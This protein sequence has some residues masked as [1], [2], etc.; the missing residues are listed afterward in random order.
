MTAGLSPH[1]AL[2]RRVHSASAGA[3]QL[4]AIPGCGRATEAR[5]GNGLSP[6]LCRFHREY[7]SRHGSPLKRSYT[8]AE[9]RPHVR[10]AESFVKAHKNDQEIRWSLDRIAVDLANAGPVHRVND[11]PWMEPRAK[12]RAALAM[13]RE[14]KVP[15][16]RILAVTLGVLAAIEE[17]AYGPGSDRVLFRRVQ[18]AKALRRRASGSHVTYDS[19]WTFSRYPRSAGKVLE[20]L[21]AMVAEACQFAINRHL[22]N[23]LE[24]KIERYGAVPVPPKGTF[25]KSRY[26]NE[27]VPPPSVSPMA[28]A[29][30]VPPE[31]AAQE[32]L[33][34][35]R[36]AEE[37]R[38]AFLRD[39]YAAFRGRF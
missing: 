16:V 6:T 24:L 33:E 18:I 14:R 30:R 35:E 23:V 13:L 3:F 21:G 36:I 15:P 32:E 28:D 34:A 25:A 31:A 19:G 5:Q 2:Y 22:S 29:E 39:G 37:T 26:G 7:R 1:S 8:G 9:I 4:C 20:V 11:L 12:A 10:A 17:D 27:R 38:R